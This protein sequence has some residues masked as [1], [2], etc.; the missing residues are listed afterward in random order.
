MTKR[1]SWKLTLDKNHVCV[2]VC[3]YIFVFL[4]TSFMF[5]HWTAFQNLSRTV[6]GQELVYLHRMVA[7]LIETV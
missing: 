6:I 4:N 1:L 2:C 5:I 7:S 3:V